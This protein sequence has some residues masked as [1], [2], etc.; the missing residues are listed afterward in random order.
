MCVAVTEVGEFEQMLQ[1]IV[2]LLPA[3]CGDNRM[4]VQS[5]AP[6]LA[7]AANQFFAAICWL[8]P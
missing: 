5:R 7:M 6:S 8:D 3:L 1:A 2:A 4:E